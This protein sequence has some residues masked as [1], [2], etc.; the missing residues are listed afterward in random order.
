MSNGGIDE[1]L[2]QIPMSQLASQLGVGEAE[3]EQAVRTALPA[4]LVGMEANAQDPAGAA[5]LA[6]ALGQHDGSLLDGGIDLGQVDTEDGSKI[7]HN[8]FGDKE[9]DVVNQLGGLGGGLNAGMLM[10]LL[11]LLAPL[12]LSF[13]GKKAASAGSGGGTSAGLTPGDSS[14]MGPGGSGM[15]P[16]AGSGEGDAG[17]AL[18][19]GGLGDILGGLL[20]GGE[21]GGGLGGLGDVLGGLLGGGKR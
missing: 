9:E 16:G 21:G 6:N 17:G 19:G 13:L 7:V 8:I 10:K 11:P 5:S 2:S 20:G 14:A 4:L 3:A 15:G 18:G 12:L 1:L